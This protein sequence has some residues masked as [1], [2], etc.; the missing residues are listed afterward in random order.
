V[1]TLPAPVASP[2]ASLG[3]VLPG[4]TLTSPPE[5]VPQIEQDDSNTST[6]I[7]IDGDFANTAGTRPNGIVIAGGAL[8]HT[9]T[10]ARSS[11]GFDSNGTMIVGRVSFAGTWKGTGQRRPVAAVNQTPGQN[12]TVLFTPAYG[13]ATPVVA[14]STAVVLEPFPTAQVNTDLTATVSAVPDTTA[15]VPIPPDG[16]VLLASG[17]AAAKLTAEAPTGTMVTTRLILP[18]VWGSVTSALGGGPLLVK[19]GHAVFHTTESL[20]PGEL[21]V[22]D[23]RAAVGQTADGHVLLVT[24]D[25]GNPGASVGMTNYDLAQTMVSLGAVTAAGLQYGAAVTAA[26][27]GQ[28]LNHPETGAA[29]PVHEALLYQYV[30]VY[31]PPPSLPVVTKA[32]AAQGESLAYTLVR[33]STVTA[34]VIDP[35]GVAQQLDAGLRNP[36]TYHFTWT[37]FDAEGTWHWTIAATDSQG[38]QSTDDVTFTYD[39][40]LSGLVVPKTAGAAAGLK[41]GFTLSRPASV[42]LQ[43]E[44]PSGVVIGTSAPVQLATGAQSLTWMGTTSTG[45]PA[46]KGSYVADVVASSAIGTSDAEAP[47]TWTG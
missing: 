2:L 39:L 37:N 11:I 18:A 3:P 40:T 21:A 24:V 42:A 26:F 46:P 23:A 10:P 9:P 7:G 8:E 45:A 17:T 6:S 27:A 16:A 4:G 20:D 33:P 1:I 34:T 25:G 29:R 19:G 36:G 12:Q 28:L 30:G 31:A 41:V 15:P 32:N 38:V 13:S 43:I 47:F 35:N 22:Q 5:S 44:T 14:N